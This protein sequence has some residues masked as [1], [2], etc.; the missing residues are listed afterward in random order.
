MEPL[1][2]LST[3]DEMMKIFEVVFE[4][5]VRTYVTQLCNKLVTDAE[6]MTGIECTENIPL[7]MNGRL[8]LKA[9]ENFLSFNGNASAL[10]KLQSVRIEDVILPSVLLRVVK[11][12]NQ[13]DVDFNFDI[14]A[15][16]NPDTKLWMNYM[17][18]YAKSTA[19]EFKVRQF[20]G[21]MEPAFDVESRYFTGDIAGPLK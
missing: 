15:L 3:K 20:F 19:K 11:Y 6:R 9:M 10:I 7:A 2:A 1:K 12:G 5:V 18:D 8:N 13:F 4:D 16:K 14:D 21:G 17:H